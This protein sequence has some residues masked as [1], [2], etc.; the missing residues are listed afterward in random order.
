MSVELLTHSAAAATALV[1]L[2]GVA[3][4]VNRRW[5]RPFR[6]WIGSLAENINAIPG[7]RVDINKMKDDVGMM[8]REISPNHGSSLRDAVDRIEQAMAIRDFAHQ[9][10]LSEIGVA[11]FTSDVDGRFTSVNREFC[12]MT[13]RTEQE[14]LGD[15]W[16]NSIPEEDRDRV[17]SSWRLAVRDKRDWTVRDA[18]IQPESG[19]PV[20]VRIFAFAVRD[21]A[22]E[23][24][25]HHG[26]I[27]RV[28]V[29]EY[30]TIELAE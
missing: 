9:S 10:F 27:R 6:E 4:A 22:G 5:V 3:R 28:R 17:V 7:V 30:D 24:N 26:F 20:P 16:I 25:G 2:Y 21:R 11:T 19:A 13:I 29:H 1:T 14:A 12:R 15:R 18:R 8:K 23:F